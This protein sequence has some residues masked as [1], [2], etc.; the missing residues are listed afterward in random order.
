[1]LQRDYKVDSLFHHFPQTNSFFNRPFI[2]ENA[3]DE[4]R[5]GEM[6]RNEKCVYV[7]KQQSKKEFFS[8]I[9]LT[10]CMMKINFEIPF[11]LILIKAGEAVI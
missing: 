6:S 5:N 11:L 10:M 9:E 4:R 1:M 2:H 7:L 3:L 8:V